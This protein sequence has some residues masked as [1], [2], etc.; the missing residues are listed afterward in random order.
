MDSYGS[1]SSCVP[2]CPWANHVILTSCTSATQCKSKT[3]L[4]FLGHLSHMLKQGQG[5]SHQENRHLSLCG[6][7]YVLQEPES[8]SA[9]PFRFWLVLI[10][11]NALY[12]AATV[13]RSYCRC[14]NRA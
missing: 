6:L 5:Q 4:Y 8:N 13:V 7:A 1:K 12:A 2:T 10:H 14:V 3:R 11:I 9:A